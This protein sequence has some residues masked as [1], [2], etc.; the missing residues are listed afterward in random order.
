LITTRKIIAINGYHRDIVRPAHMFF[1][2]YAAEKDLKA[3]VTERDID[4]TKVDG[5]CWVY[6]PRWKLERTLKDLGLR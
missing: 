6:G 5:G 1:V 3:K 4:I 2:P